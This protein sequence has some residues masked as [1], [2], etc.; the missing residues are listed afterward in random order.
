MT[1]DPLPATR[2][3]VLRRADHPGWWSS[4]GY[5]AALVGCGLRMPAGVVDGRAVAGL[6]VGAEE[7]EDEITLEFA[8]L[9]PED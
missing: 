3:V 9:G 7:G 2:T 4:P 1:A 8:G 5:F 6:L